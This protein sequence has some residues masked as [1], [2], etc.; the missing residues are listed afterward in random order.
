MSRVLNR[1]PHVSTAT[2]ERVYEAV[3]QLGYIPND[4]A[5]TLRPGQRSNSWVMLVD[6]VSSPFFSGVV[7]EIDALSIPDDIVFSIMTSQDR[8]E[9]EAAVILEMAKR[10][11]DGMFVLLG[12]GVYK[13]F[14]ERPMPVP[15]VFLDRN[16]DGAAVNLVTFDYYEAVKIAVSRLINEGHRSIAYIGGNWQRDPGLRK[17]QAYSDSL[18]QLGLNVDE[19]VVRAMNTSP[20]DGER[21]AKDLVDK[22]GAFSAV[23]I[24]NEELARGAL[25]PL[26]LYEG[27][28][29]VVICGNVRWPFY[30]PFD[31]TIIAQNGAEMAKAG[32][33]LLKQQIANVPGAP[34]TVMIPMELE[35][36][37]SS[38][39]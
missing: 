5:R 23:V 27:V 15:M 16:P 39:C 2:R 3:Q 9:R 20:A 34:H 26:T 8:F 37:P 35:R 6:E 22:H 13:E 7:N 17:W 19:S 25:R 33:S 24:T 36:V 18:G 12:S 21:A 1:H 10:R 28:E 4:A 31:V 11:I 30:F 14:L 32:V 29:H 38:F